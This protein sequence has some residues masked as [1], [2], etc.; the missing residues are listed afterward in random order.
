MVEAQKEGR[1][2]EVFGSGTAVVISPVKSIQYEGY[3]IDVP[4]GDSVGELS[5]KL[6]NRLYDIQYGKVQHEWSVVL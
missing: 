5:L 4:T 6:W 2:L 3:D 1:L